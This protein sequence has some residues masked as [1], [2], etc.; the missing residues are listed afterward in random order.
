M[1]PALQAKLGTALALTPQLRQAIRLLQLSQIELEAELQAAVESNPLLELAEPG[2]EDGAAATTLDDG[3]GDESPEGADGPGDEAG[4]DVAGIDDELGGEDWTLGDDEAGPRQR[5][6]D[7][8]EREDAGAAP[9][10]HEHLRWQLRMSVHSAR[11]EAIGEAVIDA[12]GDDG[13]LR[14]PLDALPAALHSALEVTLDDVRALLRLVQQFDPI[15]CGARDLAECLGLQLA[16]LSA[17]TPGL[18]LAQR[19]VAGHLDAIARQRPDRLAAE[20]G[21]DPAGVL[22]AIALV[23]SLD[24]KPGARFDGAPAEY[25]QPDA[26]AL[27]Q[28][29]VWRVRMARGGGGLRLNAHYQGLIGRCS[30]DDDAYLRGQLQEARWLIKALENR[31]ETLQRVAEAIVRTQSAFLDHGLEAMR[32]LTLRDVAEQLDLHEST[33]S[34]AT[35]RKYLRTPRG[36]F[37]FKFFFSA[38]LA[39]EHGGAASS[40]AVQAMIRKMIEAEPSGKPLSDQALADALKAEGIAVARRTVAKYREGL[41]I[42]P[43]SERGQ[44]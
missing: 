7:D 28:R 18:A 27:K 13:Y 35:T 38:G 43:S 15:G 14:E 6:D 39:T 42:A 33:I 19:L 1:K 41:G 23:K 17:D 11:D 34:R 21:A 12:L 29:G 44:R 25:V 5:D 2:D 3:P 4:D 37:E 26:I 40:T 30:R 16:A 32:P 24:P 31:G 20:L 9:G 22:E 10:L 8:G 36:T